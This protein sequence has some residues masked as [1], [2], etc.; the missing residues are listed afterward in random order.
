MGKVVILTVN[1]TFSKEEIVFS[2]EKKNLKKLQRICLVKKALGVLFF[3]YEHISAF[4][5]VCCK[6]MDYLAYT[7]KK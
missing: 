6:I 7:L 5:N 2:K 1:R 3:L 4:H